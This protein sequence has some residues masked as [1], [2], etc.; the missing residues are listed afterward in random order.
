M[1]RAT[2]SA[3]TKPASETL[4]E[5]VQILQIEK[6]HATFYVL[7]ASTL[8]MN[9]IMKKAPEQLLLPPRRKNN[10]ELAQTL[11]HDPIAEFHESIYRCRDSAAPTLI[12]LP[13]GC[14]KK[15]IAQA[16][17]DIPGATK[18][19]IGR[20]V[21]VQD[22]TVH[23]YG[24]PWLYMDVVRLAGPSHAPD[25]RTRAMFPEWAC[26]VTLGFI[27]RLIIE[28]DL[29]NLF[30]A[31]GLIT[32]IGD[33]RTEKGSR[34]NGQ[35]ELVSASNPDWNRI[36]REQGR[37]VQEEAM[38]AAE[39]VDADSEEL[40]SWYGQEIIRREQEPE[41]LEEEDE[42][43]IT[44]SGKEAIAMLQAEQEDT[45]RNGRRRRGD[46]KPIEERPE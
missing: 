6:V 16:A 1:A 45:K 43:E 2:K 27:K 12:H 38:R 34:D 21:S 31:A 23:L 7:G 28:R 20:L 15:A 33:G 3:K 25:I 44:A 14:F 42:V 17:I 46:S 30:A 8:V 4:E 24:K 9:R 39:A 37:K 10:A 29:M 22:V 40:L 35:W 5:T 41:M 32:G 11:K 13:N 18:A 19:Q 26:K 36:V